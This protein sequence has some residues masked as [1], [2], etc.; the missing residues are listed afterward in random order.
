[1]YTFYYH[2]VD[3]CVATIEMILVSTVSFVT[4]VRCSGLWKF[5]V[6]MGIT[7]VKEKERM[8]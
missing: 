2:H 3:L 1:M 4:A 7:L 5:L 8:D 6:H